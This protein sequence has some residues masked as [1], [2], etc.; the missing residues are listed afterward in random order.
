MRRKLVAS[1]QF[2]LAHFEGVWTLD[3][4]RG[5]AKLMHACNDDAPAR[6]YVRTLHAHGSLDAL[7]QAARARALHQTM[8]LTL[9][10]LDWEQ[11]NFSKRAS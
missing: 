8:D 3:E 6:A 9:A 2:A 1:Y 7:R 11:R 5:L 4:C 10:L